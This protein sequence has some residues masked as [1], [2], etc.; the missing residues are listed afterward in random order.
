ML[1][2]DRPYIK[3]RKTQVLEEP[4]VVGVRSLDGPFVGSALPRPTRKQGPLV[5]SPPAG[6]P[7]AASEEE[8]SLFVGPA[9]R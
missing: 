1:L 2:D 4:I 6:C 5:A 9:G 3:G 8:F 7:G